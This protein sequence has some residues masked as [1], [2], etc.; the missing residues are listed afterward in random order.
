MT[1]D[2]VLRKANE[3]VEL[4]FPHF[5]EHARSRGNELLD[6]LSDCSREVL[7]N[8]HTAHHMRTFGRSPDEL[9]W[10]RC[11]WDNVDISF[12]RAVRRFNAT[13]W[14][15][16]WINTTTGDLGIIEAKL[17]YSHL[18]VA[19]SYIRAIAWQLYEAEKRCVRSVGLKLGMVWWVSFDNQSPQD[20]LSIARK[21]GFN[22]LSPTFS[23]IAQG[24]MSKIWPIEPGGIARLDVGLFRWGG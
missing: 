10:A 3:F 12:G 17:I 22:S 1:D 14:N 24:D 23:L 2:E 21:H 4:W 15:Q 8:S 6:I 11:E 18:N 9:F 20:L 5:V 19:E 16:E 7:L 13:Q